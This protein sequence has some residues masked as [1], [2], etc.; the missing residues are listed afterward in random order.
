MML[1]SSSTPVLGSLLSSFPENPNNN[2]YQSEVP[3]DTPTSINQKLSRGSQHYPK[4]LW[5]SSPST[6]SQ[7][8]PS[9]FRRVQSD[10]N[11]EELA[12]VSY[13]VDEFSFSNASKKFARKPNCFALE[14]IS[15]FSSHNLGTFRE[16]EDSDED[17]DENEGDVESVEENQIKGHHMHLK[18]EMTSVNKYDTLMF[19]GER[20]M[21]LATGFGVADISYFDGN[22]P[23]GGGNGGSGG[24]GGNYRPVAFDRDGGD[25]RGRL[26]MEEHYKRMLEESPNNP[27]F[28]RNYA[29]FLYQTKGDL[30]GAEEYYSRAILADPG[31]GEIL[32]QY[33]K[34][35]WELHRDEDRATSYFERAVQAS[36]QSQPSYDS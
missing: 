16:D 24:G 36:D 17:E 9:G 20:K 11:L 4:S 3:K 35:V 13:N 34:L 5:H 7:R 25:S 10:G 30:E 18:E 22:G 29:Q 31:D 19:E 32:S 21:Y 28:L 15:S 1:R 2:H 8:S 26:G 33:A 27:L 14:P 6:S 23:V 12:N